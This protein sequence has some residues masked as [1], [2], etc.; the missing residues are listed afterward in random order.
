MEGDGI[1]LVMSDA[2]GKQPPADKG[3]LIL[4]ASDGP[5]PPLQMR[6]LVAA[7]CERR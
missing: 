7:L 5:R 2:A 1:E 6:R 4:K 3:I